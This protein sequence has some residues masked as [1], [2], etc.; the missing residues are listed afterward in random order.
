MVRLVRIP[1]AQP[2]AV[3]ARLAAVLSPDEWQRAERYR[4]DR[5]RW[6]FI[7]ARA[8]LRHLLGARLGITPAE[9][10]LTYGPHG[11]PTLL[12]G[13]AG[14]TFNLS[15]SG[16]LALCALGEGVELGVDVE[17]I[18]PVDDLEALARRFFAPQ[19]ADWLMGHEDPER[20]AAFFR[21]WTCKEA[22][23]K[24]V[25]RGLSINT[26]SFTIDLAAGTVSS[27]WWVA[28]LEPGS[29]YAGALCTLA[30]TAVDWSE[31]NP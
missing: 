21:M 15:H 8:A 3:V 22:Y 20:L 9:V 5:S 29:G 27:G 26:R 2:P 18:R 1:L 11:K 30:P 4:I 24:A 16:D 19:E 31:W 17:A 23:A 10:A 14:V 13:S 7:V 12:D 25:G 28:P 6:D